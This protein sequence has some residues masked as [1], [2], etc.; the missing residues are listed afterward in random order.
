MCVHDKPQ[1]IISTANQLACLRG[2]AADQTI[3]ILREYASPQ[4]DSIF[5]SFYITRIT[6]NGNATRAH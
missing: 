4:D 2:F 3:R 1:L 5:S 6:R